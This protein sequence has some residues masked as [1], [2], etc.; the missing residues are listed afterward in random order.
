VSTVELD[1]VDP[2]GVIQS[3]AACD[4]ALWSS[5]GTAIQSYA[6]GKGY[7]VI[8]YDQAPDEGTASAN[9]TTQGQALAWIDGVA[10][11]TTGGVQ[12]A[13]TAPGSSSTGFVEVAIVVAIGGAALVTALW[14]LWRAR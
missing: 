7:Q 8:E 4:S 3:I 9:L 10:G 14:L 11:T 12:S 1:L 6:Q 2:T 13:Q 5:S